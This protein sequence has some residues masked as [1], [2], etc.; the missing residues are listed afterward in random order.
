VLPGDFNGDGRADL[1]QRQTTDDGNDQWK[2]CF[3]GFTTPGAASNAFDCPAA[4]AWTQ[5]ISGPLHKATIL[6]FNG[7]G[8]ADM[9]NRVF[10]GQW[11]S[12]S[13]RRWAFQ[14][15]SDDPASSDYGRRCRTWNGI[16]AE[17]EDTLFGD[18][19]GDGRSDLATYSGSGQFRVCLST[20]TDFACDNWGSSVPVSDTDKKFMTG[21]LNGDGRT[22]ILHRRP[23]SATWS[24]GITQRAG[25]QIVRI[26][27]GLGAA[28]RVCAL[29]DPAVYG[30]GAGASAAARESTSSRRYTSSGRRRATTGSATC[31]QL[32]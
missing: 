15:R 5:G 6:D 30:K 9:A 29:T 27:N 26:V 31:S 21:D 25:D 10:A 23:N 11:R 16:D 2:I 22:D 17:T 13:P 24:V 28:T 7:D 8:L 20:G 19:N 18:F 4:T 14:R 3:S 12:V 32:F 1:A